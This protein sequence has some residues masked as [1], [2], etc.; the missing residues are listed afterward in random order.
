MYQTAAR[1]VS[2]GKTR[3]APYPRRCCSAIVRSHP[4]KP[5]RTSG[6]FRVA[7]MGQIVRFFLTPE[8]TTATIAARRPTTPMEARH[9]WLGRLKTL[10]WAGISIAV[11]LGLARV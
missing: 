9:P 6:A 2:G 7:P 5:R 11:S 4:P 3:T 1:S 8:N 10:L